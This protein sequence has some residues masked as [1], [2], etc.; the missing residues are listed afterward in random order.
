MLRNGPR[1]GLVGLAALIV[2]LPLVP[3]EAVALGGGVLLILCTLA[4]TLVAAMVGWR[5]GE[6][7]MMGSPVDLLLGAFFFLFIVSGIQALA[8]G[9]GRSILNVVWQWLALGLLWLLVREWL[10]SPVVRRA[11]IAVLLAVA[12]GLSSLGFYQVLVTM[13]RDRAA[14]ERDPE[15]S[16]QA[17]GI[18]APVGSPLRAQY[19]DRLRSREPLATFAL[20]NSLA[21]FL[22]PWLLVATLFLV[23]SRMTTAKDVERSH[24]RRTQ[25]GAL[26]VMFLTG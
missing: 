4:L 19:E 7:G 13:P 14:F 25:A 1:G 5:R 15:G 21:G 23:A 16:L 24:T 10:R 12:A 22:V 3:S 6:R 2:A 26:I 8:G 20:T 11:T 18:V 17:A 9:H